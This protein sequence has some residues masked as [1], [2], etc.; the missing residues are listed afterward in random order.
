MSVEQGLAK[1]LVGSLDRDDI[2]GVVREN[3]STVK[4]CYDTGLVE[5]PDAAG[6]VTIQFVISGK[7][8]VEASRIA[9]ATLRLPKV[10]ECVAVQACSWR[11]PKPQPPADV[12]VTYPFS[13]TPEGQVSSVETPP[14]PALQSDERVGRFA[15]C[16]ARR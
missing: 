12:I 1:G 4:A 15:P 5:Q 2:R 3:L 13:F 16:R 14:N 8:S 6:R 11:F 9:S 7:G 10:A